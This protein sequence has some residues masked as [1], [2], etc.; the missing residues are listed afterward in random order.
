[1]L[2]GKIDSYKSIKL[3]GNDKNNLLLHN[4]LISEFFQIFSVCI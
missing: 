1:M 2:F 4:N 3:W